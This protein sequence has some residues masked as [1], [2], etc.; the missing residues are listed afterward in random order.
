MKKIASPQELQ[1]EIQNV[2]EFVSSYER[3]SREVVAE[4]LHDLADR[5]DPDRT[6]SSDGKEMLEQKVK[7]AEEFLKYVRSVPDIDYNI[8][9]FY[10][11]EFPKLRAVSDRIKKRQE[12]L[13]MS[14]GEF[15]TLGRRAL[16]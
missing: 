4:K 12:A 16:K 15:V 7:K 14:L 2:L 11:K 5:L 3:P 6:A 9:D 1:T 10:K 13:R 8:S